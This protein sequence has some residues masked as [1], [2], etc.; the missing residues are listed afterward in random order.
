M[1]HGF[2]FGW[3]AQVPESPFYSRKT[4]NWRKVYKSVAQKRRS[5]SRI[6]V[7]NRDA[8]ILVYLFLWWIPI[9]EA[10]KRSGRTVRHFGSF[11]QVAGPGSSAGWCRPGWGRPDGWFWGF[12]TG[13]PKKLP[14]DGSS[15]LWIYHMTE[16][17][18]IC[19]YTVYTTYS[20]K[21]C[22][23]A[24]ILRG[25]FGWPHPGLPVTWVLR[26]GDHESWEEK[27]HHMSK[28]RLNRK[29]EQLGWR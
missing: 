3:N 11:S 8:L 28:K 15:Y 22:S 23:L 18:N 20:W 5:N 21:I 27:L 29:G 4:Q 7:K 26:P 25:T 19:S 12:A 9:N 13:N 24:P 14:G 1:G 2:Q 6:Q 16:G 17:R 10:R